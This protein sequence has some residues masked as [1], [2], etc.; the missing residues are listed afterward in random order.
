MFPKYLFTHWHFKNISLIKYRHFSPTCFSPI[1][2][3]SGS[4]VCL[5]FEVANSLIIGVVP[6]CMWMFRLSLHSLLTCL[7]PLVIV[8]YCC[9]VVPLVI[10]SYCCTVVR[11]YNTITSGT[12]H[13]N[14]ERRRNLNT[15]M[16]AGTT[17]IIRLLATSKTQAHCTPWRWSNKTETCRR[18]MTIFYKVICF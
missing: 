4:T 11:Q 16:H 3:S 6:A 5:I 13:V 18:K 14:K 12:R 17:P 8:S 1:G 10:V 9:I 15:H 2:P 7:V